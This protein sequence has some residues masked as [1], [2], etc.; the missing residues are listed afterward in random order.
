MVHGLAGRRGRTQFFLVLV[1]QPLTTHPFQ[2]RGLRSAVG[3]W[4]LEGGDWWVI[5]A[6]A[7]SGC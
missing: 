2:D 5:F 3:W 6:G 7:G 1:I 4:G